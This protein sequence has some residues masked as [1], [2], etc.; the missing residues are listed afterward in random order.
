[1]PYNTRA[2]NDRDQN[3]HPDTDQAHPSETEP[4]LRLPT[5]IQLPT[6]IGAFQILEL[7]GSGGMG[8]VYL[9]EQK[10]P[11]KRLVALK[12][13]KLGM[14]TREVITRFESERQALA[15]MNH[16]NVA[17]IFESGCTEDGRPFFVMEHVPGEKITTYCDRHKL[18]L[19]SRL[20]L[21]RCVCQAIHHAHQKG[22]I[23]RDIKPS[24]I[25]VMIQDGEAFPKVI[26][27]GV[28]KAI[29]QSL[30]EK[31]LFTEQGR[32]I[33]TPAYMSPEQAE[34]T[35]LNIDTT[36]D[37]YSLGVLLY[38]ILVGVLPFEDS[39]LREAGITEMHH[40]IRQV[41]YRSC[42]SSSVNSQSPKN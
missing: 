22:I 1:M 42:K 41:D 2:M 20:N 28:A 17:K 12:V 37:V 7:L 6:K 31:T 9:A 13:I 18:D 19:K 29:Q 11:I 30:T 36:S 4:T 23:H 39:K 24:N 16:P 10:T 5:P 14:D 33:G 21:F 8:D 40:I 25:L 27:F 26:D 35:G 38:E 15:M 32:M 34:M 3:N